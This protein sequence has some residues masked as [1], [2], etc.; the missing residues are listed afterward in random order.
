MA[1][2]S[3]ECKECLLSNL[4]SYFLQMYYIEY[5]I[6]IQI[7]EQ[8]FSELLLTKK[9]QTELS[10]ILFF[11]VCFIRKLLVGGGKDF[12]ASCPQKLSPDEQ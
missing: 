2:M 1:K 7:N 3:N 11:L 10:R 5:I 12:L 4:L 6:H 8:N 9:S